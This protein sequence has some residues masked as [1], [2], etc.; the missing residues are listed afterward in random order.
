MIIDQANVFKIN[1]NQQDTLGRT[2]L[3]IGCR[4][5]NAKLVNALLMKNVDVEVCTFVDK[6]SALHWACL[7]SNETICKAVLE[8]ALNKN[9]SLEFKNS[10]DQTPKDILMSN[11]DTLTWAWLNHILNVETEEI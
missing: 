7:S 1:I 9:V 4:K 8:Y 6:N 5:R 2:P 11:P 10:E 3:I